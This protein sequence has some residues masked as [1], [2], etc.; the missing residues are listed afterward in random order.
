MDNSER[1]IG[2]GSPAKYAL[3]SPESRAAA[4]ALADAKRESPKIIMIGRREPDGR[5]INVLLYEGGQMITK[6][7]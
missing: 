5:R 4:R 3:G 7:M 1:A 6:E 2:F